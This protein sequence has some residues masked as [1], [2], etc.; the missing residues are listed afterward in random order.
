MGK[1]EFPYDRCLAE[2]EVRCLNALVEDIIP[3]SEG[4][5]G[6][7]EAGVADFIEHALAGTDARFRHQY[8]EGLAGI[9]QYCQATYERK[10]ADLA[11]SERFEVLSRLSMGS[12]PMYFADPWA[13]TF[14]STLWTHTIEGFLCD[15]SHGGNRDLVGWR[16]VGFPGPYYGF[17][18]SDQTYGGQ[19]PLAIQTLADLRRLN[20]AEPDAFFVNMSHQVEPTNQGGP[21]EHR[22]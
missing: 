8:S 1:D 15:P 2:S 22:S 10:Y 13:Q 16:T 5:P 4:S 17:T 21:D 7:R 19:V 9:D 3:S 12:N 20:E 6:A 18:K 11:E 14:F